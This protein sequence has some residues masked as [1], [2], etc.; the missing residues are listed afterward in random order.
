[1]IFILV[2]VVRGLDNGIYWI[3]CCLVDKCYKVNY[4]FC[5]IVI[6]IIENKLNVFLFCID[7]NKNSFN[8]SGI[9][10]LNSF[11]CDLGEV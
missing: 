9:I 4:V 2:L 6:Y 5:W 3:Y 1:M 11:F 8:Y 7:Y 10:F